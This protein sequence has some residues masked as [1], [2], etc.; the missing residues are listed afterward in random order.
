MML[1]NELLQF[2]A[3]PHFQDDAASEIKLPEE[4]DGEEK[5]CGSF[6]LGSSSAR[7]APQIVLSLDRF[8]SA[9]SNA[10]TRP[11]SD[12]RSFSFFFV[13]SRS[14]SRSLTLAYR[15]RESCFRSTPM[16]LSLCAYARRPLQITERLLLFKVQEVHRIPKKRVPLL[17]MTAPSRKRKLHA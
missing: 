3:V 16:A 15:E 11:P 14:L 8:R 17:T 1:F 2:H 10:S 5:K 4:L 6:L 13:L 9:P 7:S 12:L